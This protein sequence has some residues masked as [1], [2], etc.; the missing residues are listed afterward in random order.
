MHITEKVASGETQ[1]P[2]LE[3]L[4]THLLS[5]KTSPHIVERG[6]GVYSALSIAL[7][8]RYR[9]T[10]IEK[11]RNGHIPNYDSV[12]QEIRANITLLD[13]AQAPATTSADLAIW[14]HPIPHLMKDD[15][16]VLDLAF[17][18]QDVVPGGFLVIQTEVQYYEIHPEPDWE[19]IH[20][21][22]HHGFLAPSRFANFSSRT[23]VLRR[24]P[25]P[26]TSSWDD[27][28]QTNPNAFA[29]QAHALI[30]RVTIELSARLERNDTIGVVSGWY[31]R[32]AL[33]DL[34][35]ANMAF[36]IHFPKR[37]TERRD[38]LS[39]ALMIMSYT[40]PVFLEESDLT[41]VRLR[42]SEVL[43]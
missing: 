27:L 16:D 5:D 14:I 28:A 31:M 6:S 37:Y 24:K 3:T 42:L 1:Y 43:R 36:K 19:V 32:S 33:P 41:Q 2:R 21:N 34:E 10:V 15:D 13:V 35:Q 7:A 39:R 26:L 8:R 29:V 12:P 38:Q 40:I 9:I 25:T 18:G 4:V 11:I 20:D 30:D 17:M 23:I 22:R